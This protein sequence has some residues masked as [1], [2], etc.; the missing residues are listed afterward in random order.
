MEELLLSGTRMDHCYKRVQKKE[1][2]FNEFA[3]ENTVNGAQGNAASANAAIGSG[4]SV[5]GPSGDVLLI[6]RTS[7]P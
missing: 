3:N 5:N 4:A 2:Q 6:R 7:H 1:K